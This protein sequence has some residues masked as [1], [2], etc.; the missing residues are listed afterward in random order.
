MSVLVE[1]SAKCS[2]VELVRGLSD[3]VNLRARCNGLIKT[4]MD[5]TEVL[6]ESAPVL[7]NTEAARDSAANHVDGTVRQDGTSAEHW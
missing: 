4:G 2:F 6:S 3:V 7:K 1:W 5:S